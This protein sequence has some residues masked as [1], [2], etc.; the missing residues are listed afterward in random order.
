MCPCAHEIDDESPPRQARYGRAS[1]YPEVQQN[2]QILCRY[3]TVH[4]AGK[5][6]DDHGCTAPCLPSCL[7]DEA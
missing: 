4:V 3:A 5:D 1:H 2:R 7:Y 6:E